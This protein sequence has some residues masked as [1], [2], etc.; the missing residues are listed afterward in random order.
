M[1]PVGEEWIHDLR[2]VVKKLRA[3]WII[4]PIGSTIPFK[5]SFPALTKLFKTAAKTRDLQMTLSCLQTLPD[6]QHYPSLFQK[7]VKEIKQEQK[8]LE[9]FIKRN[10]FRS[11]VLRDMNRFKAYCKIASRFILKKN[12]KNYWDEVGRCLMD[13]NPKD[14]EKMHSLRKVLKNYMYQSAAFHAEN[15]PKNQLP[16]FKVLEKIQK[17]LGHW[18][19]WWNVGQWLQN[20][21]PEKPIH[22]MEDL[23]KQ[24]NKKEASLK[25]EMLRHIKL[26]LKTINV[27]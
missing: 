19:D 4:H 2:V 23:K 11:E 14:A 17:D 20:M 1:Q 24:V 21:E 15:N 7:L 5:T 12:K 3:I 6:F 10:S 25:R 27:A 18:H 13:I 26:N 22:V 16:S 8:K 9:A